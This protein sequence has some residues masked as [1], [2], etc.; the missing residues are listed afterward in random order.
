MN[1]RIAKKLAMP[2]TPPGRRHRAILICRRALRRNSPRF[3]RSMYPPSNPLTHYVD[4]GDGMRPAASLFEWALWFGDILSRRVAH[5]RVGRRGVSTVGIGLD[6]MLYESATFVVNPETGA[7][8]FEPI[9]RYS[10]R[11][12]AQEGH[13]QLVEE[14][15]ASAEAPQ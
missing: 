9:A 10:T 3:A 11:R 2:T 1:L 14:L 5:T 12:E 6:P 8:H 7:K 13:R 4:D 15:R